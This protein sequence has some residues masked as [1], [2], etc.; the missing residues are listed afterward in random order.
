MMPGAVRHDDGMRTTTS[1]DTALTAPCPLA[2]DAVARYRRDGFIRLPEVLAPAA[3]A[4]HGAEI[5]R[6]VQER[7]RERKPLAERSTYDRAFLQ[8]FNLWTANARI[9]ELVLSPRLGRIAAALM[10]ARGA[11]IYHDQA[12]CKEPGGGFTPW[13]ADQRYWPLADDRAVTA[14]IPLQDVPLEMGPLAFAVGSQ[15]LL[16]ER[17]A[18][19]LPIGDESERVIARTLGDCPKVEEPY[20]LGDVSFHHG[21]T[22][23]R[24]GPNRT[25][26]PRA[27]MTIIYVASDMVVAEPRNDHQRNDLATWFPGLAPGD[28]AASPINPVAW[29]E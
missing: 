18:L 27:V 2:A 11:R 7:T 12:L 5:V 13:H 20:R 29:E 19:A 15:D 24:A 21:W 22:F 4:G 16:A 3:L 8:V 10:G 17:A 6:E 26:A 28:V 9:A 14:W 1:P 25:T 23:H